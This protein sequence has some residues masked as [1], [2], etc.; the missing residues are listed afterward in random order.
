M[1]VIGNMRFGLTVINAWSTSFQ[2]EMAKE[3]E[4][5]GWDGFFLWDHLM[6]DWDPWV[7]LGA[8]AAVTE[9][10]R[11]GPLVTPLARR[12]PQKVAKEAV[13]L[14]HLS[15]GRAVLGVGLGGNEQEFSEFGEESDAKMRAKKLD[16][17]LEVI[18]ELWS[19]KP[20]EHYGENY[21][22]DNVE[23][24]VKPVQKPRI[25]IWVGGN[26]KPALRRASRF[27]G[28]FP[29][30]PSRSADYPGIS[31]EELKDS[32]AFVLKNRSSR[33]RFEIVYAVETDDNSRPTLTLVRR[34]WQLGVTWV[35]ENVHGLRYSE[36]EA[37]E[38]IR[39]GPPRI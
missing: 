26:S 22:V 28:W 32:V 25:P 15:N 13:T 10:M 29:E 8:V 14:D 31:V 11:L 3:A 18:T 38:R 23:F 9:K 19:E 33:G 24:T 37:L 21:V 1:Q 35:L 20:V 12:R 16:E 2:L 6:F 30:C 34:L 7:L 4:K 17:A 5:A 36:D 39:M 27:D